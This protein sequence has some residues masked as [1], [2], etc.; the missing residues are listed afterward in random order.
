ML[1]WSEVGWL[2]LMLIVALVALVVNPNGVD[3]YRYPLDTVNIGA[4][5][6]FVGEWQPARLDNLF[7]WLLLGFI[8]LGVMPT[9]LACRRTMRTADAL[10]L[11]GVSATSVL[12]IRFLLITGPVGAAI[13]AVNLAPALSRT[14][15]GRDTGPILVRLARAR[16]GTLGRVNAALAV[17]LLLA[18]VG[19]AVVRAVPPA[20]RE[21]IAVEF[22][23]G[24]ADWI[25]A[26]EPSARVFNRYEWGGYLGLRRPD[27]PIY[28]DGR[29]DVYGDAVIREYV[30]VI[31]LDGDPQA[32]LDRYDIDTV[33]YP[34]GNPFADW[35]D[36]QQRWSRAYEDSLAVIWV[37]LD[38]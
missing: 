11:A 14:G 37:R 19:I 17:L 16:S 21:G 27:E 29:A 4:L 9:L 12:A 15:V 20:Q 38:D 18:G 26:N 7:G 8:A 23:V 5:A 31:G 28:I 25:E 34:P 30:A 22:P 24:A 36:A 2:G 1:S 3:I 33:L 10:I 6:D 32:V 35:L 13:I